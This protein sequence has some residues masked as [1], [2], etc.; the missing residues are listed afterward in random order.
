MQGEWLCLQRPLHRAILHL[1]QR[2][3]ERRET[4]RQL[5]GL[6][7]SYGNGHGRK[8]FLQTLGLSKTVVGL[9]Q[10]ESRLYSTRDAQKRNRQFRRRGLERF[11]HPAADDSV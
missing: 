1:R 7:A 2:V 9:L 3:C 4:G 8:L 6:R 11:K 10:K 5:P